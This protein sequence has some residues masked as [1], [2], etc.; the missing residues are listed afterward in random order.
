MLKTLLTKLEASVLN[1]I[2]DELGT[3][4]AEKAACAQQEREDAAVLGDSEFAREFIGCRDENLRLIHENNTKI[5]ERFVIISCTA[6][7]LRH[8]LSSPDVA[9]SNSMNVEL[10]ASQRSSTPESR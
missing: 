9:C 2:K 3:K 7:H 4:E 10:R 5:I 6:Q 8:S 1:P